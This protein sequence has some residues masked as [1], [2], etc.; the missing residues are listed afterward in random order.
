MPQTERIFEALHADLSAPQVLLSQVVSYIN[1]HYELT[2]SDVARFFQETLPTL[3]DYEV[4][5]AFSP[6]YTPTEENRLAYVPLLGGEHVAADTLQRL[7]QRLV[8]AGIQVA[9]STPDGLVAV[10]VPLHEMFVAR[11]VDRLGLD[12][13]LPARVYADICDYVPV[14]AQPE[15]N[16]LARADAWSKEARQDVLMA[17]LRTFAGRS[18]FTLDKV[19]FL[20]QF[21][22]TYRTESLCDVPRQLEALV[23]SCRRD[24]DNVGGRGFHDEYL[25]SLHEHERLNRSEEGDVWEHY[26][27][28]MAMAQLVQDDYNQVPEFAA[29]L[30][31]KAQQQQ[32]A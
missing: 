10:Q 21:V 8:D 16:L 13:A 31:A 18:S 4:D 7:K 28:M 5:L 9:M 32:P 17:F 20:T 26:R 2:G 24:M 25:R 29:S 14:E 22:R 11:Y 23:E 3:E 6:Q 15:V 12:R 19:R 27:Q 1:D 30:W